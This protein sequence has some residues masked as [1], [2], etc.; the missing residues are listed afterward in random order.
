M[1]MTLKAIVM[2]ALPVSLAAQAPAA[3]EPPT[4]RANE[5]ALQGPDG[6]AKARAQLEAK[7][8]NGRASVDDIKLLRAICRH[9]G[10]RACSER[11]SA[12]LSGQK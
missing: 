9:M 11:A 4:G 6:E 12:L 7:V 8:S 5:L 3:P 1:K 2:L 10:D